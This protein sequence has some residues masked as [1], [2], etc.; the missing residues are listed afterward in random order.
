MIDPTTWQEQNYKYF[1]M[2][3]LY[4]LYTPLAQQEIS[5]WLIHNALHASLADEKVSNRTPSIVNLDTLFEIFSQC[6]FQRVLILC[7]A[8]SFA[9]HHSRLEKWLLVLSQSIWLT[10]GLFSILGIKVKATIRWT[11]YVLA[12][13]FSFVHQIIYQQLDKPNFINLPILLTHFLGWL[14]IF[15]SSVT[16][17]LPS[18]QGI[19]F[20][21][22]WLKVI[23]ES[24]KTCTTFNHLSFQTFG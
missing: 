2:K 20:I 17:Y 1:Q 10:K 14:Q 13:L 18:Y 22:K 4:C 19:S 3:P 15:P 11:R 8:F 21:K 16:A 5:V 12:F 24:G 23:Q 9:L 6:L 7:W